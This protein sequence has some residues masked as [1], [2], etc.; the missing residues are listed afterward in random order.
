MS[1]ARRIHAFQLILGMA[2][3]AM[4]ATAFFSVRGANYYIDRVQLSR[5]QVDAISELAI[6]ANRFSEQIAELLLIGDPERPDFED[7]RQRM[8]QQFEVLQRITAEEDDFVRNA[9]DSAEEEEELRRLDQMRTLFLEIDRAVER[10]LLL[11]QQGRRDEAIALFRSD[12][13]NRLDA[14]FETLIADAVADERE[15]V[16][17]AD[18]IAKR[19]S[20][21]LMIGALLLLALLVAI[22]ATAG[23]LFTRSLRVP[24]DALVLGT[25]ALEQGD[26]AHRIAYSRQDEFG[27]LAARF[28]AM[29]E[30]LQRQRGELLAARDNLEKQVEARTREI[31]EANVQLTKLDQH[32]VHFLGDV[33]HELRTPLTVLRAE[34]EVAL[35]GSSKPEAV[36]R[37]ALAN[38][39]AQAADMTELV[40][41]LLF[42]ARSEADEIRFDF[43]HVP[44]AGIVA[45]AVQDAS[46][47]AREREIRVS[48]SSAE[49][50]PI[51]RADPRR[52][53]QALLVVL[54]N[55][56]RYAEPDTDIEVDV[57]DGGGRAEI[58]VRDRGAGIPPDEMPHIF[59]RFYRG[60]TA[61]ERG[62]GSGLG[63]AIARWIVERHEGSIDV[64]S[65]PGQGTE[66]RLSLPL[67]A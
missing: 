55:A 47:L 28:N 35:R 1:I 20:S 22:V 34:A 24:I 61:S 12:I 33:S 31:A 3:L 5:E 36:Y 19:L 50:G 60:S 17:D 39:V 21:A 64:S 53:K 65:Q 66:V 37:A 15:D 11:D 56:A 4:A 9:L 40:E 49:P 44:V 46:L 7:A 42:L 16:A 57:R 27:V 52:L 59:D 54:D 48:V 67:A 13:E 8:A 38:I 30:T 41:D 6:R 25:Q 63:L 29:A 58:H 23:F 43:R 51:V 32:R 10:V 26:L 2:M 14:D 45:Q 18:A 62:G